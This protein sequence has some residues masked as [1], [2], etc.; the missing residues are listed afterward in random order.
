MSEWLE[1]FV[2]ESNHI[3]GILREPTEDEVRVS[4]FFLSLSMPTC[5]DME[6]LVSVY[7]PDARLRSIPGLNVRVGSYL[8]PPGGAEVEIELARI[9][10]ATRQLT[11]YVIHHRYETLHPFTDGNGR[12]GRMLWLW[13]MRRLYGQE[14]WQAPLG[15]LHQWYYQSLEESRYA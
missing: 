4:R 12:S 13:C 6:Q 9:L 8:A 1:K 5:E 7:Q 2:R 3:E 15:F 14:E 10:D 11:P